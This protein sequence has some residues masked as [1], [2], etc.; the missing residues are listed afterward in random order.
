[1]KLGIIVHEML[2]TFGFLHE[3]SRTDRD[4]HVRIISENIKPKQAS[5]FVKF[6]T[7][8]ATTLN[9]PYDVGSILHYPPNAFSVN[10]Q[11]TCQVQWQN[12]ITFNSLNQSK[13]T[14]FLILPLTLNYFIRRI[15]SLITVITG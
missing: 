13:H 8:L 15:P 6:P 11:V 3:Q 12:N 4:S 5:D 9:L 7:R 2:H 1:M 14:I 10:G